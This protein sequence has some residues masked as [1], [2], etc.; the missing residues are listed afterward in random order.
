MEFQ[1]YG[2]FFRQGANSQKL[3]RDQIV[4]F[5]SREGHIHWYEQIYKRFTFNEIFNSNLLKLFLGKAGFLFF[6]KFPELARSHLEFNYIEYTFP[7]KPNSRLQK[8]RLTGKGKK[9]IDE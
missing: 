8:Y 3:N 4:S 1:A 9:A 6:G 2:F 7:D 5:V